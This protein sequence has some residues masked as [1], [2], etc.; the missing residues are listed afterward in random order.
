MPLLPFLRLL[1]V[2]LWLWMSAAWSQPAPVHWQ[3]GLQEDTQGTPLEQVIAWADNRWQPVNPGVSLGFNPNPHWLRVDIQATGTE[4]LLLHLAYPHLDQVRF[5]HVFNGKVLAQAATG[6]HYPFA[7]RPMAH[8]NFVFDVQLSPG[9]HQVYLWVQTSGALLLPLHLHTAPSL[10]AED[11]HFLLGQGLFY[12]FLFAA[13]V[14]SIFLLINNRDA[15]YALFGLLVLG[16]AAVGGCY[17]GLMYA[18]VWP[19]Y[20]ALNQLALPILMAF[21][22]ACACRFSRRFFRLT[23]AHPEFAWLTAGFWA[24]LLFMALCPLL[25]FALAVQLVLGLVVLTSVGLC[26]LGLLLWRQ[27]VRGSRSFALAWGLFLIGMCLLSLEN[28][29]WV[30]A[31]SRGY[32]VAQLFSAVQLVVLSYLNSARLSHDFSERLAREFAARAAQAKAIEEEQAHAQA[33]EWAV[34]E[35]TAALHE[36]LCEVSKLNM[37][38]SRQ[39]ITDSLTG[40]YNRRH[41][42]KT[43]EIEVRRAAREQR[44]ISLVLLDVDHF[45]RINDTY[46]H[47]V[48][49]DCLRQLAQLISAPL[50]QPPDSAFR[51]GGEEMALILPG[52]DL[53]GAQILAEKIRRQV[54]QSEFCY[55]QGCLSLTLSLGIGSLVP[56]QHTQP[57]QVFELADQALYRAKHQGRN[58]VVAWQAQ[59]LQPVQG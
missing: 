50:R 13:G 5:F 53:H 1:L 28:A 7:Q 23:P 16:Y 37:E 43:L 31:D 18:Y 40:L 54:A 57:R 56:D 51:Y 6:D 4:S 3:L 17:S 22:L 36:A 20:S 30:Y 19:Q 58:C 47:P 45:K 14:F 10:L 55:P 12:G 48:G 25:P 42:D 11:N 32:W 49:D 46:G 41:F 26:L 29:G 35:K 59:D 24:S 9:R 8:R 44:P 38:L 15:T 27:G 52:A 39:T 34:A 21:S 2:P 33:L